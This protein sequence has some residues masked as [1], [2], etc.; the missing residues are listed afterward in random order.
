MAA[1]NSHAENWFF[2]LLRRYAIVLSRR[3][4]LENNPQLAHLQDEFEVAEAADRRLNE[5]SDKVFL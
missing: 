3:N 2:F 1:A 4:T 5:N